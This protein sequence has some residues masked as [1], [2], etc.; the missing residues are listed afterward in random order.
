MSLKTHFDLQIKAIG[1]FIT[2]GR[3]KLVENVGF[4]IHPLSILTRLGSTLVSKRSVV[5]IFS[6]IYYL[7]RNCVLENNDTHIVCNV[8]SKY[9]WFRCS[10]HSFYR[11][12]LFSSFLMYNCVLK[13]HDTQFLTYSLKLPYMWISCSWLVSRW[14]VISHTYIFVLSTH[15]PPYVALFPLFVSRCPIF[16]HIHVL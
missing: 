14:S 6:F 2:H 8:T 10:L 3:I 15:V 5:F 13:N 4:Y 11:W 12:L 16:S 1:T 9:T 7:L